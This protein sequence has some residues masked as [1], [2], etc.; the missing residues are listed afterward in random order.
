M[1]WE[2]WGISKLG[3]A[4]HP[5]FITLRREMYTAGLKLA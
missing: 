4:A 5:K 3:L 1:F 2:H